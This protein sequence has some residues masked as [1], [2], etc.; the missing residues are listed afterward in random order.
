MNTIRYEYY[1]NG[2]WYTDEQAYKTIVEIC[3][4]MN[5]EIVKNSLLKM[6]LEYQL[7]WPSEVAK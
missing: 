7:E 3:K 4:K 6:Q 2:A 5:K 1:K